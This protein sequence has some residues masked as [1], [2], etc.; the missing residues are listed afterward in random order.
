[1]S[2]SLYYMHGGSHIIVLH[3]SFVCLSV[4]PPSMGEVG[5]NIGDLLI[6][7]FKTLQCQSFG[8]G[9]LAAVCTCSWSGK[10]DLSP[11]LVRD[12]NI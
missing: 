12:D 1:M 5:R 3:L 10:Q 6:S 11:F 9:C 4:P 7:T 8:F 2:S